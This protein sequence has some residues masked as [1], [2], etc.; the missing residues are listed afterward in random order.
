MN[1][2]ESIRV[3]LIGFLGGVDKNQHSK[4]LSEKL[5]ECEKIFN[6]YLET[7]RKMC[8]R[9]IDVVRGIYI[10]D[11]SFFLVRSNTTVIDST[12]KEIIIAPWV[13]KSL[14]DRVQTLG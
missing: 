5:D 4:Q 13:R 9:N 8:P 3:K 11:T 1:M 12:V 10:P 2:M 7:E 14:I 6:L